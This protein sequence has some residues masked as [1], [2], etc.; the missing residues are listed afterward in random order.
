[1]KLK[2]LLA[3]ILL[4]GQAPAQFINPDWRDAD[5]TEHALWDFFTQPS[6]TPNDPDIVEDNATL[7]CTTPSAFI[8][9][10]GNI[11]SHQAPAA[12]QLDDSAPFPIHNIVLQISA[13]GSGIDLEAARLIF[14]NDEGTTVAL[15][16][17]KSFILSEE[18]LGGE[19]GG[20]G[21]TYVLQWNPRTIPPSSTY[22]ILFNASESSLSLDKLSLDTS[23]TF[24]PV[25]KPKP[26][27]I[28]RNSDSVT[29]TW[30][31]DWELQSSTSLASAWVT[32]PGSNSTNTITLPLASESTFFRLKQPSAT[33]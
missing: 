12:F 23:S 1:M 5:L 10:S 21:T 13:L 33:E 6:L 8:T 18:E 20:L 4:S 24:F 9:S 16:P 30:F 17:L 26:L 19:R 14:E 15:P 2:A 7:T 25:T 28:E 29:L 27:S 3:S 31:G 32:V 11:Y 22:S